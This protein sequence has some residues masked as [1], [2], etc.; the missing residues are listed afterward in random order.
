MGEA[1]DAGGVAHGDGV[2]PA[3]APWAA[4]RDAVLAAAAGAE[5]FGD[6][7]VE[8]GGEGALADGGG[9]GFGDA[10]GGVDTARRNAGADAGAGD[11][12]AGAG[13]VGVVAPVD[14][15]HD[16]QLTL[17]QNRVAGIESAVDHAK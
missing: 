16:A 12:G 13:D 11:G 5:A 7:A 10:D 8:F 9:E 6:L 15:A 2:H 3:D 17:E 14:V 1:V 4:G